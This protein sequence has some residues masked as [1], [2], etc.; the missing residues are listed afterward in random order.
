ISRWWPWS[1]RWGTCRCWNTSATSTP[2]SRR[3]TCCSCRPK[4]T[5]SGCSRRSP[6]CRRPPSRDTTCSCES[7]ASA[8][9]TTRRK[10]S[11]HFPS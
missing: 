4:C 10:T 2:R 6:T 1:T 5:L 9:E 7:E 8:E 3:G 11:L